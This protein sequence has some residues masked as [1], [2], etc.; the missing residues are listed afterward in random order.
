MGGWGADLCLPTG[1]G[2]SLWGCLRTRQP[3]HPPK[4]TH[5][6][7][8]PDP[9]LPPHRAGAG[10]CLATLGGGGLFR[11]PPGQNF[12]IPTDRQMSHPPPPGGGGGSDT[13]PPTHPPTYPTETCNTEDQV[14][15]PSHPAQTTKHP[16]PFMGVGHAQV[17]CNDM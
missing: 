2:G 7:T 3:T 5:P 14:L 1:G 10:F 8:H 6:P 16:S 11:D 13:H 9:P 4:L 12:G 15:P 17:I